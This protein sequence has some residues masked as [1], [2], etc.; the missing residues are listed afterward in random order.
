MDIS[1]IPGTM[2]TIYG[3]TQKKIASTAMYEKKYLF[4]GPEEICFSVLRTVDNRL[5][6]H[7]LT[8]SHGKA[9]KHP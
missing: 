2:R 7:V 8:A 4:I 5:F 1:G 6:Q 9:K 3:T